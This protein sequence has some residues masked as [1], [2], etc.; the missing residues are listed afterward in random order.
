MQDEGEAGSAALLP[1]LRRA[2][3]GF[4]AVL[5]SFSAASQP[6]EMRLAA[7][8]ALHSSTLLTALPR[9]AAQPPLSPGELTN[10]AGINYSNTLLYTPQAGD[11]LCGKTFKSTIAVMLNSYCEGP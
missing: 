2:L 5:R 1:G 10:S 11:S 7:I 9:P 6:S 4:L 3:G 8:T